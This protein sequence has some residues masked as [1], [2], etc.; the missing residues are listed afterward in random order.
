MASISPAN[1]IP[2]TGLRG[3]VMPKTKRAGIHIDGLTRKPRTKQ[4]LDV[5]AVA[6]TLTRTLSRP[7][8]G[9]SSSAS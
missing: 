2:R 6:R 9:R 8:V 5:T 7:G 3:R 1:T 4:S